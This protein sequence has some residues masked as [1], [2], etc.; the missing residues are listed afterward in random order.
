MKRS[1]S[2][3][4]VT[5]VSALAFLASSAAAQES[6]SPA[7]QYPL[8]ISTGLG[9]ASSLGSTS[10]FN[11]QLDAQYRVSDSVSV[12]GYMQVFAPTGGT[13]F[14]LAGDV[15]YHFDIVQS[16]SDEVLSKI[17]PYAGIG[18]GLAHVGAD[19]GPLSDN[20]FLIAFIVG[21]EYDLTDRVALTS[22]M[23][24]NVFVGHLFG[25]S[26][27]FSWQIIGARYRF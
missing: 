25:D 22:D 11:W 23:R 8:S 18:M 16:E 3:V 5:L 1:A 6:T 14:N 4:L 10:G 7:T 19:F 13:F 24:F 17:T 21:A 20:A 9:F 2:S 15:R 26:F 12:G 27:A